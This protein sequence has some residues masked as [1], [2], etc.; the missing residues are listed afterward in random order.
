MSALDRQIGRARRRLTA[1]IFA[2]R[3]AFGVLLAAGLW[4]LVL[5]CERTFV[6]HIPVWHGVWVAALLVAA[7]VFV[8]TYLARV[9]MLQAAVAID[10]AAGLKERLSTALAVRRDND[11]FARLAVHDA[12]QTA[13]RLHVPTHLPFAPHRYGP[14]RSPAYWSPSS[15][16]SLCP[17]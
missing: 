16:L 8:G 14:G 7:V 3:L 2:Q 4:T 15:S 11:P 6:L 10:S 12:E 5:L 9:N 1:N 17:S 13:G